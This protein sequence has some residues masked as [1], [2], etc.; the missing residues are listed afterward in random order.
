MVVGCLIATSGEVRAVDSGASRASMEKGAA[1]TEPS[2]PMRARRPT[3]AVKVKAYG[4]MM[5]K[6]YMLV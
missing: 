3:A 4:A 6:D 1:L 2:G 5:I